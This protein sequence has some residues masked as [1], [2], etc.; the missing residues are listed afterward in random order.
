MTRLFA[1]RLAR[2]VYADELGRLEAY[3]RAHA[4]AT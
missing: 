2:P 3:A 4:P 1:P